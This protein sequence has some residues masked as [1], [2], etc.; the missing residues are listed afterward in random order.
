MSKRTVGVIFG[1]RSVEH[2]VSI[3]TAIQ[4]MKVLNPARYDILPIYITRDGR[5]Y[6]GNN[7]NSLRNFDIEDIA[8]LAGTRPTHLSANTDFQGIITP[9]LSGRL[10]K[11]DLQKIDVI[12]PCIHG[13]HGED[14]TLQGLLEL[15]DLPYVGTG[16]LASAIAN[17]KAMTK[18]VLKGSGVRVIEDYVE[19]TRYEWQSNRESLLA[20]IEKTVGY[21]A[22]VKP[23][24]L[25]SSIGIAYLENAEHAA[26]H[27]DIAL[28]LD[29]RVLVERAIHGEKIIEVNCAVMGYNEIRTST[30]EKPNTSGAFLDFKTKYVPGEGMKGQDREV[31]APISDDLTANIKEA[32]AKA[33][34]AIRGA[35]TARLDFIVNPDSGLFWLNEINTLPG[36][37][38]FYLWEPEGLSPS[39]VCDDLIN[40]AYQVH[41]EKL[42]TT[43]DYKSELLKTA[44][45]RGSKG[46]KGAKG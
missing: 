20:K 42:S 38:A 21:P 5:W 10:G 37:L 25:G 19:F 31:P 17:D 7:L 15:A 43:Y 16:V 36:S 46:A 32:S 4:V 33:F 40:I 30:L 24:T 23:V 1:S 29:H 8:N 45:E 6:T 26:L 35:G 27:I 39:Q 12:F 3:V 11:S 18:T 34:K 2:D 41:A 14:G 9:P 22:F 28:N 13:S 44:A